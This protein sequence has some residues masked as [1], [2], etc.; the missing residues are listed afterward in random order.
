MTS[1]AESCPKPPTARLLEASYRGEC[2]PACRVRTSL[3]RC[4]RF[5]FRPSEFPSLALK[6]SPKKARPSPSSLPDQPGN[7]Q[8]PYHQ[9]PSAPFARTCARHHVA[10][11]AEPA[12][13]DPTTAPTR[14]RSSSQTIPSLQQ[15]RKFFCSFS[16]ELPPNSFSCRSFQKS[17]FAFSCDT[18]RIAC[19]V[20]SWL[21]IRSA[22]TLSVPSLSVIGSP[23]EASAERGSVTRTIAPPSNAAG[24]SA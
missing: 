22:E 7:P 19:G 20:P 8:I 17:E 24:S 16:F 3:S 23:N 1:S 11:R 2:G 9:I 12:P 4:A 21:T 5:Y 18:S 10:L 13:S 14:Y 15:H 6:C